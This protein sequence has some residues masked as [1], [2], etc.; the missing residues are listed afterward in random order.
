MREAVRT[1]NPQGG[2]RVSTEY[3]KA[4]LFRLAQGLLDD[5]PTPLFFGGIDRGADVDANGKERFYIGRRH[6]RD[7]Q[8]DPVVVDWRAGISR[9]FYRASASTPMGVT[10]RRRFGFSHG[11]LTSYE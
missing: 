6:V 7:A 3:L 5:P 10:L 8:G 1:L 9:A 4:E 11:V 2:D